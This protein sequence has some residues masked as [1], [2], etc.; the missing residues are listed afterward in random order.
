MTLYTDLNWV[1][2]Q[3]QTRKA[4]THYMNIFFFFFLFFNETFVFVLIRRSL[5]FHIHY[6]IR[7]S[8]QHYEIYLDVSS[9]TDIRVLIPNGNYLL[10]SVKD[11]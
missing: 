5:N 3:T 11:Y 10:M 1:K 7:P 4:I 9:K 8:Y 6:V 2:I